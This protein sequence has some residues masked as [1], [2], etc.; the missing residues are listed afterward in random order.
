MCFKISNAVKCKN[1]ISHGAVSEEKEE[2]EELAR[3]SAF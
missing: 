3:T 2:A 1:S